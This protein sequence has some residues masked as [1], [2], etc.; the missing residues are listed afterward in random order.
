MDS[1]KRLL[2]MD[3]YNHIHGQP[4]IRIYGKF[5]KNSIELMKGSVNG[6][7]VVA[8][9]IYKII[10]INVDNGVY[11]IVYSD[12]KWA[13][14]CK[15]Y[16]ENTVENKAKLCRMLEKSIGLP[17]ESLKL[18]AIKSFYWK[19]GTHYYSPLPSEFANRRQFIKAAQ[20]PIDNVHVVGEMVS[21]HQGWV[22]GAL[23]SVESVIHFAK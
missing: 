13:D 23:E 17:I 15:R 3:I 6:E 21:L 22:E 7:M 8:G 11:M 12:N 18:L 9:P 19:I 4:F 10:P 5:A 16:S 2:K 20:H 14:Y 1:V